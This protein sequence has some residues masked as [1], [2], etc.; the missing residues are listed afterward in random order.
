M[1]LPPSFPGSGPSPGPSPGPGEPRTPLGP[2]E[3][4]LWRLVAALTEAEARGCPPPA[5]GGWLALGV[6]GAQVLS[7]C[8]LGRHD[9][10]EDAMCE[11]AEAVPP[12]AFAAFAAAFEEIG[13]AARTARPVPSA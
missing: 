8:A 7:A 5:R 12:E 1:P 4:A 9:L 2:S 11:I 3:S 10:A 6:F 13:A